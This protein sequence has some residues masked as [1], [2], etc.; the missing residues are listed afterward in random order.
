MSG[1]SGGEYVWEP[2]CIDRGICIITHGIAKFIHHHQSSNAVRDRARLSAHAFITPHRTLPPVPCC[3]LR[4]HLIPISC[5]P[6]PLS[7]GPAQRSYAGSCSLWPLVL[8]LEGPAPAPYPLNSSSSSSTGAL[9]SAS[10][11]FGADGPA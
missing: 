9:G 1:V 5:I 8:E 6:P 4:C 2:A 10:G 7:K 3:L 11:A